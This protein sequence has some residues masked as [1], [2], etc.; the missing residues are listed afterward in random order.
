MHRNSRRNSLHQ[1]GFLPVCG[2]AEIFN[3]DTSQTAFLHRIVKMRTYRLHAYPQLV[4]QKGK[5]VLMENNP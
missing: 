4:C 5:P 2:A 3:T 1:T